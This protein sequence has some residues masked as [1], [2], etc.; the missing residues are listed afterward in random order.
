MNTVSAL[1]ITAAAVIVL[2][3]SIAGPGFGSAS[4][5]PIQCP[6]ASCD[7]TVTVA[8]NPPAPVANDIR[9]KK[10]T[11]NPVITWKL[12]NAPDYEFRRD[13]IKPHTGAPVGSKQPTTQAAWDAQIAYQ[14]NNDKQ[15][16]VKNSNSVRTDLY[17]DI[18][19]YHKTTGAAHKL[20][21][22]IFNDP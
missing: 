5:Q 22:A 21:P 14:N 20:D 1:R 15:Y 12:V 16:K 9:M 13:S 6:G 11:P 8:G 4:A 10:G 3:C 17:Y 2:G 7:V 19:V 18:T